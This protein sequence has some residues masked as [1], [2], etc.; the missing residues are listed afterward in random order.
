ML[1]ETILKMQKEQEME[2][3][4]T[5]WLISHNVT[6]PCSIQSPQSTLTVR[7]QLGM[8]KM[9]GA[10]F[11]LGAGLLFSIAVWLV[12]IFCWLRRLKRQVIRDVG[13]QLQRAIC[14]CTTYGDQMPMSD[15]VQTVDM[16]EQTG[17]L[18]ERLYLPNNH[19]ITNCTQTTFHKVTSL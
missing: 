4:R 1:S 14:T 18:E 16:Q 13:S 11:G 6:V 10:F 2:K 8:S 15:K 3:L 19:Q 5:K 7:N 12:E 17:S 9:S